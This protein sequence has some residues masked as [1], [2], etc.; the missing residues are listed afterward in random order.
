[1]DKLRKKLQKLNMEIVAPDA[2]YEHPDD[3]NMR[4]WWNRTGNAYPGLDA[5]LQQIQAI[6]TSPSSTVACKDDEGTCGSNDFVGMLGFSQGARLVHLATICHERYPETFLPGLSF[7]IMVAGYD[8]PIP[9]NFQEA[10]TAGSWFSD[11][12]GSIVDS[13]QQPHLNTHSLHVWGDVDKLITP[14]QSQAV[15]RHYE[16]PQ[17]HVHEGG[18]HV[19]M[20]AATVRCFIEFIEA[21]LVARN[22]QQQQQPL[23]D[24]TLS[25]IAESPGQ[26]ALPTPDEETAIAQVDE[27]E[28]LLAIFPDEFTLLSKKKEP[29]NADA[30][31]SA[32]CYEHPIRYRLDLP[33]TTAGGEEVE[34][35]WPPHPV[36]IRVEYPH[37]YPQEAIPKLQLIHEN[38]VMEFSTS[39]SGALLKAM[40]EAALAEEGMPCVLSCVNAAREFFETGSMAEIGIGD[41]GSS[42][43]AR[44][45]DKMEDEE[46]Q[47]DVTAP[48]SSMLKK[49]SPERIRE[50][51]LQGMQL[52]ESILNRTG[53]GPLNAH[54]DQ[55]TSIGKGGS[56]TYTIGLV[57]KPSAGKS[58][59]FNAATAF[60]RQRDDSSNS[61]GGATMA[62]HPFTTIDPNVGFCLVPAPAGSC[63]E[64]S[65]FANGKNIEEFSSTHGRDHLG[66]RL[67][68]VLLKDV[69]GL[70]PGA[71]QG[72]GRGNKFLNDLTD[73]D[74][75][76]HVLDGSGLADSEGNV[77]LQGG[78][79]DAVSDVA[80]SSSQPFAD[81]AWIQNEL[82]EWVY[83]NLAFKWET[84]RRKGRSKLA[85]M[86]SGYGQTQAVTWSVLNAVERY[87]DRTEQRHRALDRL[88]EWDESD[89][90]RLVSAFLGVRFPMALAMNKY[91]LPT[92]AKYVQAIQEA[93]PLHGA[94][95]GIPLSA[96]S[97]MTF[98]RR[99]IRRSLMDSNV[100][101]SPEE[102]EEKGGERP[103]GVWQCLQSA[104]TLRE[105]VLVFPVSNFTDCAPLPG[106]TTIATED[107][108]LPNKGMICCIEQAGGTAPTLWDSKTSTY[109]SSSNRRSSSSN[110]GGSRVSSSSSSSSSFTCRLRDVLV[111]KPGSTVEDAFVALKNRG[112]LS[113]EFVRAEACRDVVGGGGG[114]SSPKPVPKHQKLS[115]STRILKI[116]TTKRGAAAAW[117][118]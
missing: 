113:G 83:A 108:S 47:A 84:I 50:C 23:S 54:D 82:V 11:A 21:N 70:V 86:F 56:W 4:Q 35:I 89:V 102:E 3:V 104:M 96:R 73:A 43:G 39:Q 91:D 76:I 7:A 30:Y 99:S 10:C 92:S 60:A 15:V 71:Y 41:T 118:K 14:E 110:N 42:D 5:T 68:P 106:M 40:E 19:P 64:E 87:L 44:E 28:A 95:V 116:M 22:Q 58:T 31:D 32:T 25:Q 114:D 74:V 51:N 8:A 26:P 97:E 49:A 6:W 115:A 90:H 27:V 117:Q 101:A 105:P 48:I 66:R 18:H 62:P 77:L 34:G 85:G 93:L 2:L 53:V 80:S 52:A 17:T 65:C 37:N 61:L 59:F 109:V 63:P 9:D 69:A 33:A 94:R 78:D 38:N 24:A 36:A 20:R 46:D 1:M 103:L 81:V 57:G 79:D 13:F 67:I 72:R 29:L 55:T 111:M 75:L 45:S 112:A 12:R 88:D 100:P 107:P 98:V 16:N